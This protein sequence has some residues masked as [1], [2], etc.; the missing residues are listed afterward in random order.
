MTNAEYQRTRIRAD[1]SALVAQLRRAIL[2]YARTQGT[3]V[4][5][6]MSDSLVDLRHLCDIWRL[7]FGTL[8]DDAYSGYLEELAYAAE[9]SR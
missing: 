3:T 8:D 7:D 9:A 5:R 1:R 2:L 6:A 4:D